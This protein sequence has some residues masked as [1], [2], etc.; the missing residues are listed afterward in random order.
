MS[1]EVA[2][3]IAVPSAASTA[4][5][6]T[7]DATT[8]GGC[9]ATSVANMDIK[10]VAAAEGSIAAVGSAAEEAAT[11]WRE[12]DDSVPLAVKR[13][14]VSL[15]QAHYRRRVHSKP[16]S[17]SCK[18]AKRHNSDL[19]SDDTTDEDDALYM[20]ISSSGMCSKS[21]SSPHSNNSRHTMNHH[22][23]TGGT[24][25]VRTGGV[26][27]YTELSIASRR[28]RR[29]TVQPKYLHD[30]QRDDEE[31]PDDDIAYLAEDDDARDLEYKSGDCATPN[32]TAVVSRK[33]R[34]TTVGGRGL[35]DSLYEQKLDYYSDSNGATPNS[36]HGSLVRRRS[37]ARQYSYSG[38]SIDNADSTC[39]PRC[40]AAAAVSGV[41]L[42]TQKSE[43]HQVAS[44][45]FAD[46]STRELSNN[47]AS[48]NGN[49][50]ISKQQARIKM[51]TS[52]RNPMG[53][54]N[55]AATN[56]CTGP[57][58]KR[59][60][61]GPWAGKHL[62]GSSWLPHVS[63]AD[64]T[65]TGTG[66]A[67]LER[68]VQSYCVTGMATNRIQTVVKLEVPNHNSVCAVNG[69][70]NVV[71]KS[72]SLISSTVQAVQPAVKREEAVHATREDH[73]IPE[74]AAAVLN[75]MSTTTVPP[76][77]MCAVPSGVGALSTNTDGTRSGTSD[78]TARYVGSTAAASS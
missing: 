14:F 15:L 62:R 27:D 76:M 67:A 38:G 22:N 40:S 41:P 59:C 50:R 39:V 23:V 36:Q 42:G 49:L 66:V 51:E 55:T 1:S 32:N 47:G 34:S 3:L 69:P 60:K 17:N 21:S 61:L 71:N 13:K 5:T 70:D 58:K 65:R 53:G 29:V 8:I 19:L 35:D 56:V 10:V 24:T 54:G 20:D 64:E 68:L 74:A 73:H 33:T 43:Q 31:D 4:S 46:L 12:L 77:T 28:S 9:N 18:V 2:V 6:A 72:E 16:K 75:V 63:T 30:E 25:A 26:G 52:A 57:P 7:G 11:F 78:S 45:N 48:S 37:S 44:S